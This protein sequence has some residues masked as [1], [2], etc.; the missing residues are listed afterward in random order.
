MW[1]YLAS[2][3]YGG[4]Q[5][6]QKNYTFNNFSKKTFGDFKINAK[7]CTGWNGT[8]RFIQL[9]STYFFRILFADGKNGSVIGTCPPG[10]K[11]YS[12]PA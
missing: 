9:F 11:N 1:H 8:T 6:R 2:R 7:F 3:G 12:D 4:P 10:S 5:I